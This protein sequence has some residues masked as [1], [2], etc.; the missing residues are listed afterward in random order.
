MAAPPLPARTGARNW[1]ALV[2]QDCVLLS[3]NA[4]PSTSGQIECQMSYDDLVLARKSCRKC[5]ELVNPADPSHA[6]YDGHE[7]GPWSRWLASRPAKLILVGQ[8]WG[9][10]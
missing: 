1:V 7:V 10:P 3:S 9:A 5:V 2:R 6:D 4:L 8:D